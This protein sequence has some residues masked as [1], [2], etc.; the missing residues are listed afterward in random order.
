MF[1]ATK[2]LA[3]ALGVSVA[4]LGAS[5]LYYKS[6]RD[7]ALE[8]LSAARAE[9]ARMRDELLAADMA[10][11]EARARFEAESAAMVAAYKADVERIRRES[12][13]RIARMRKELEEALQELR[14]CRVSHAVVGL[15]DPNPWAEGDGTAA[16][17]AGAG[18]AAKADAGIGSGDVTC[19]DV[20][21][22]AE[23]LRVAKDANDAQLKALQR[24]YNEL[25]DRNN[26][27]LR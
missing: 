4:L 2:A 24:W 5:T 16:A 10:A 27:L 17:A 19:A 13:G 18:G 21:V 6:G 1:L 15:L 8:K 20:V 9:I 11:K 26:Q 3:V 14:Q 7:R 22:W 12:N 23:R 25:R